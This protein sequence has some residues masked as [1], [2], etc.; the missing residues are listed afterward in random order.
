MSVPERK[1][2]IG[3][4]RSCDIALAHESVSRQHAQPTFIGDGRLLL[5][6]CNST[7]G[8]WLIQGDG[9]EKRLRQELI[10]PLDRLRFGEI[11]LS[12]RDLVEALRLKFP[13]FD[14]PAAT[15]SPAAAPEPPPRP[16]PRG[17]H[18]VRCVCG[19]IKPADAT[20]SECGR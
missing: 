4:E 18:L 1:F 16:R 10:S 13:Q 3:R 9:S 20:C 19:A 11:E 5:T 17:D 8:T 14:A 7:R 2:Q 12:V 15:P 6:D